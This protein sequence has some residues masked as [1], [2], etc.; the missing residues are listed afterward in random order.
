VNEA[1]NTSNNI[2][3]NSNNNSNNQVAL[4]STP[5]TNYI[6]IQPKSSVGQLFNPRNS[7]LENE[8][9]SHSQDYIENFENR[10]V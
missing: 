1:Q 9:F 7:I 5:S 2:P 4:S 10:E 6:G 8:N 3:S